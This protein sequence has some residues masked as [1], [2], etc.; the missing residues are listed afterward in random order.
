MSNR[1]VI[2]I[3]TIGVASL[4]TAF[5]AGL[6]VT[7]EPAGVTQVD[8]KSISQPQLPPKAGA[9]ETGTRYVVLVG[10]FGSSEN[11]DQLTAELRRK[12]YKSAYTQAPGRGSDDTLYR[13]F[14]GPYE[15]AEADRVANE[16]AS[17]GRKG[18]MIKPQN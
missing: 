10:T 15:R 16:L 5:W 4:L 18:V 17:E 3:F 1:S 12:S 13:V 8:A 7:R 6:K 14:I 11:A 2:A 9:E